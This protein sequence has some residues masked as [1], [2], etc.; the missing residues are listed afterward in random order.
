MDLRGGM[1]LKTESGIAVAHPAPV[2]YHLY[3]RA[4]GIFDNQL[5]LRSTGVQCILQQLF[6]SRGGTVHHLAC[7]YLVGHAVGEYVDDVG[8]RNIN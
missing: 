8:H 3:Q 5:N 2:V 6:H 1:S 4:S 7:G